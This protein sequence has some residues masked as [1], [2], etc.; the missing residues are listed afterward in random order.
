VGDSEARIHSYAPYCRSGSRR[1]L[2][3]TTNEGGVGGTVFDMRR[4]RAV[5]VT[6]YAPVF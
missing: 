3:S 4:G 2:C 1:R 5:R 6:V